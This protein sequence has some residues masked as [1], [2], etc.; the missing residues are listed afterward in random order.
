MNIAIVHEWLTTYA[1]SEKVVEAV[2]ELY[3]EAPVYALSYDPEPFR[4]TRFAQHPVH[5]SFIQRLPFSRRYHRL[6]IPLFP[7][8]VEQF[9]VSAYDVVFSSNHAV[10]KGVLTRAGQLHVSYVHTPVRYAW[11][12]QSDYLRTGGAL[13]NLGVRLL[14]HYLR[15][16]DVV[17]ANRVDVFLANSRYVAERV[18]RTY[19]RQAQV[20]YPPVDVHRFRADVQRED[21][22]LTV[23]RFAPYKRM[24]LISDAFSRLGLP[25]VVIGEGPCRRAIERRAAPNV[26][27]LG[28]QPTEV[29]A[30]YMQRCRAFV[31]AADEDFG[32][33]PVEAMAAGAPVLAYGRGGCLETVV[34]GRT[35]LFFDAQTCEALRDA[36]ARLEQCRATFDPQTIRQHAETFSRARFQTE[37]QRLIEAEWEMHSQR[38]GVA[39]RGATP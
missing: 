33:A 31:F 23:G 11:D 37:I 10:A 32:I 38:A 29:V 28:R 6:Y 26:R 7:L 30:D 1:G 2:L 17:S 13:R 14:L 16:W 20:V 39:P 22:F 27:F 18:R 25:L 8:A 21:F 9:D 12:M 34:E 19:R 4:A 36:V 35:G 24:D 3:P 5:T 15:L